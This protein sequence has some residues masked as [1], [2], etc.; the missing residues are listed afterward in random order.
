MA[1]MRPNALAP[2]LWRTFRVLANEDRLR[3]LAAVCVSR[4]IA[5]TRAGRLTRLAA[6]KAS[7]GLRALQSRGLLAVTRESRWAYYEARSDP[8]V[9]H[10]DAV[11]S[12]ARR[13]ISR[14]DDVK[15]MAKAFTAFTHPRR[16]LLVSAMA[17]QP[18]TVEEAAGV[19]RIS[20]PAAIRHLR[21]LVRR[22]LLTCDENGVHT[23]SDAPDP[24]LRDLATIVLGTPRKRDTRSFTLSKV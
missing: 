13:A 16:L 8:S 19:C 14:G 5:V 2:S 1:H 23:L 15:A 21:K 12:A 20:I 22:G 17:R 10:A 3:L 11:L 4:R 18:M 7:L 9:E 6:D 24:L